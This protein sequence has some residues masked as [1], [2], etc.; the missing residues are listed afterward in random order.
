MLE[1]VR[2]W[3]LRLPFS[4]MGS[5]N[6]NAEW[7]EEIAG[8]A[9]R[10]EADL[11]PDG[12]I[13][14]AGSSSI[15]LWESLAEDYAPRDVINR[16]FGGSQMSD[17]I[18]YFDRIF[19]PCHPR[20]VIIYSGGNDLD[21]GVTADQVAKSFS[22]L[23]EMLAEALPEMKIALIGLAPNPERWSQREE[24][25]RLIELTSDYCLRKGHDFIDV[26]TPM[27]GE[28]GLPSRDLY[29]EDRLHMNAAGYA[30]WKRI[31]EPYLID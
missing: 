20:Q 19:P 12:A 31:V 3:I 29:V 7:E 6:V 30:M 2:F 14:F 24:Q 23:C 25:L 16:G 27:M 10:E 4:A 11:P 22:M 1:I 18:D 21:V 5:F 9:A 8:I 26:W 17:L 28:D 15:R 13:L